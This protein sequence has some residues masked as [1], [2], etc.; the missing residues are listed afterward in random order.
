M[1]KLPKRAI[2]LYGR[3]TRQDFENQLLE[4]ILKTLPVPAM[5]DSNSVIRSLA[6]SFAHATAK[7]LFELQEATLP[8]GSFDGEH[9]NLDMQS[10]CTWDP[11]S[12]TVKEADSSS[13]IKPEYLPPKVEII[14]TTVGVYPNWKALGSVGYKVNGVLDEHLHGH[15]DYNRKFR[16]GR[17]LFVDGVCMNQGGLSKADVTFW[18]VKLNPKYCDSE[19]KMKRDT[20]P[21][22]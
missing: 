17:A 12:E 16:P 4:N 1:D 14:H 13:K 11:E 9:A 18:E 7:E 22:V 21:Y 19:F 20:S 2:M 6:N 10:K 3:K 5:Q 15:I 8:Y